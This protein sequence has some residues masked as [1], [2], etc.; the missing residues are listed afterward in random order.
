MRDQIAA[1]QRISRRRHRGAVD[2]A[3]WKEASSEKIS[4]AIVAVTQHGYAIRFGYTK[5]GGAFAIGILGD[6]EPF[7]EFIRPNEDIDLYLDG[8]CA[9]YADTPEQ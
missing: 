5:D 1:S 8:L 2:A 4:R 3:D 7:T 6:G 9:D